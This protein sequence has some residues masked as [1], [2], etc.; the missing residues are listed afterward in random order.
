MKILFLDQSGQLGG[1][2][3]SLADLAVAYGADCSV[4]LFQDGPFRRMLEGRRVPTVLLGRSVPSVQKD[5]SVWQW[6][7]SSRVLLN[8]VLR[9]VELSRSHDLL[10]ANTPKALV[11]GSIAHLLTNKPLVYHLRDILSPEH[12]SD[13]NLNLLITLSNACVTRVI[14][15]SEATAA[16]FMQAG[17]QADKVQVV[18]NGF[19]PAQYQ[20]KAQYRQSLRQALGWS[21]RTIVGCF[22]RLSPWKGQSVFLEA[23]ARS[24]E[25]VCGLIVGDALF[26][27]QDYARSLRDQVVA[28]GLLDRVKFLGFRSDVAELMTACDLMAHTSIAP[29]PF[30]RVIVEAMLCQCPVVATAAGGAVELIENGETGWLVPPGEVEALVTVIQDLVADPT[31]GPKVAQVAHQIALQRFHIGNTRQQVQDLLKKLLPGPR[32]SYVPERLSV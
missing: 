17:G 27:E 26:G 12:F 5:G 21:D 24:S 7:L 29:E 32:C 4:A 10:Y 14:A 20:G 1:A 28:L 3:L 16:A 19:D 13:A 6:L 2:E 8:L 22:S 31:L 30:G 18:Y 23:L 11:V 25:S 15:N 9:T